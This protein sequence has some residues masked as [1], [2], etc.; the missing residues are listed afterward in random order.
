MRLK[1]SS[2][3]FLGGMLLQPFFA[4]SLSAKDP[5]C[6][7]FLGGAASHKNF[8]F[9]TG[10]ELEP[11]VTHLAD[12]APNLKIKGE[13]E[14]SYFEF[15]E[16]FEKV[17]DKIS[18]QDMALLE[19]RFE[20]YEV[21]HNPLHADTKDTL[22]EIKRVD[23]K[24]KYFKEIL[25]NHEIVLKAFKENEQKL[26]KVENLY[27]DT[28]AKIAR[29]IEKVKNDPRTK[30][31]SAEVEKRIKFIED[32]AQKNLMNVPD[33]IH[34]L[35]LSTELKEQPIVAED[36]LDESM[37]DTRKHHRLSSFSDKGD[38]WSDPVALLPDEISELSHLVSRKVVLQ[39]PDGLHD[40]IHNQA[41]YFKRLMKVMDELHQTPALENAL[42][43]SPLPYTSLFAADFSQLRESL[44][45]AR[46][47]LTQTL[48]SVLDKRFS[49]QGAEI[50]KDVIERSR[51]TILDVSSH[52]E[53]MDFSQLKT[54]L[55]ARD[56]GGDILN[57]EHPSYATIGLLNPEVEAHIKRHF[58]NDPL[59]KEMHQWLIETEYFPKDF[60]EQLAREK[61]N[62]IMKNAGDKKD[63]SLFPPW[64]EA[65][66]LFNALNADI[67]YQSWR[68][69]VDPSAKG[70]SDKELH[71]LL[72]GELYTLRVAVCRSQSCTGNYK[73]GELVTV[74]PL[75]GKG[76]HMF[77]KD[78]HGNMV[79]TVF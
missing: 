64:M 51:K 35:K 43:A 26:S 39:D 61:V 67:Y 58:F 19:K 56:G 25:A 52:Y 65:D 28:K 18:K 69:G 23:S 32:Y 48:P 40:Y 63:H 66:T 75:K 22:S 49:S 54:R 5:D 4:L 50:P 34:V 57:T 9:T 1:L 59:S 20:D 73:L 3:L 79:L 33:R 10:S 14:Q 77:K 16:E 72:D 12:K 27:K 68:R 8:R 24:L 37:S 71:L 36:I 7:E 2:F 17:K 62:S 42:E 31:Y 44:L 78:S 29:E 41:V 6:K 76:V 70:L 11:Y 74:F 60:H 55:R 38:P 53:T 21:D 47:A 30:A 46:Q 13:L 15:L 45:S